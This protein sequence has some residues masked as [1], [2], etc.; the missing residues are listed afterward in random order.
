MIVANQSENMQFEEGSTE[1]EGSVE[2]SI[3]S[4]PLE[5]IS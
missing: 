2:G 5:N 3:V 4:T 1:R